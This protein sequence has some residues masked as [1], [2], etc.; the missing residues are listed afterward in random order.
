MLRSK[1]NLG[2]R[3]LIRAAQKGDYKEVKILLEKG[4]D[5]N[6]QGKRGLTALIEASSKGHLEV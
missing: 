5:V 2:W 4:A 6:V 3:A 1:N